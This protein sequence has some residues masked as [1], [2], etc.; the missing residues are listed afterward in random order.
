MI[1]YKIV[2]DNRHVGG[3]SSRVSEG[4]FAISLPMHIKLN[5]MTDVHP[6]DSSYISPLG[7]C[8]ILAK[9][10]QNDIAHLGACIL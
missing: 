1:V 8:V 6:V 2:Y 10:I 5:D 3:G 7:I 9:T 4:G